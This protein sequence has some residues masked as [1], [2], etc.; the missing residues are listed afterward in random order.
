MSAT[1][2]PSSPR[3]SSRDYVYIL[4]AV[5]SFLRCDS[6]P[7]SPHVDCSVWWLQRSH[8]SSLCSH[9]CARDCSRGRRKVGSEDWNVLSWDSVRCPQTSLSKRTSG[10]ARN[11]GFGDVG[12]TPGPLLSCSLACPSDLAPVSL[13]PHQSH[14]I[15]VEKPGRTNGNSHRAR[16]RWQITS[17]PVPRPYQWWH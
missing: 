15:A 11:V 14:G 12:S 4:G 9:H 17:E 3:W 7:H 10:K 16:R 6:Q 2:P 8:R 5:I 1:P 13:F